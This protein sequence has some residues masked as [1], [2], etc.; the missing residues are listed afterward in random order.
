MRLIVSITFGVIIFLN[1]SNLSAVINYSNDDALAQ[2]YDS[3]FV[4]K[5]RLAWLVGG[6]SVAFAGSMF[7]LHHTWYSQ[8]PRSSFQFHDDLRDWKQL[9]KWGHL[10]SAYHISSISH[11]TF[12]LTGL[13]NR[14]SA[15]YGSIT[16]T[17]FMTT[18]EVFDGFSKEWGFSWADQAANM[19]GTGVFLSQELIWEEQKIKPKY[20]FRKSD[21]AD[22]RPDLLGSNYLENAIKDYNGMT[23]WLSANINMFSKNEMFPEWLNIAIGQGGYGMLGSYENPAEYN[24]VDLPEMQRYRQWYLAPDI[25][26]SKID[27]DSEFLWFLFQLL[28]FVK[29]PTPAVEYNSEHGWQFHLIHF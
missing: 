10:A 19:F 6:K 14:Q 8:H 13:S 1:S 12:N 27:T 21:L 17:L 26:L 25:D 23:F 5:Q 22:Y 28:D 2:P 11:Y 16:S 24:G 4:D 20:S 9:D 7:W 18:I 15:L 3:S 29:F